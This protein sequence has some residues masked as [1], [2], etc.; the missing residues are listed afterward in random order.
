MGTFDVS[1]LDSQN[2]FERI[3]KIGCSFGYALLIVL[4]MKNVDM[5]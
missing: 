5:A 2:G 3:A 1:L 4:N